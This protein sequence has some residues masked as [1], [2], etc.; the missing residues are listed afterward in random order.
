LVPF[1]RV[2]AGNGKLAE[3]GS[4]SVISKNFNK[5]NNTVL[6]NLLL[7]LAEA[8]IQSLQIVGVIFVFSKR[9]RIV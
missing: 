4:G 2:R 6:G 9:D 5:N 1:K 7:V 8:I 3:R